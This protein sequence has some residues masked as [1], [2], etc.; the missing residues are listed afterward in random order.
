MY[1]ASLDRELA[2]KDLG[3]GNG[4]RLRGSVHSYNGG[5]PKVQIQRYFVR[6]DGT[7]GPAKTGRLT[8]GET[9]AL[10]AWLTSKTVARLLK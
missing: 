1:D 7:T 8:A 2:A 4:S 5:E 6:Q 9:G 10:V 3:N